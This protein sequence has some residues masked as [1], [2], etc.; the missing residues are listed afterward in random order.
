MKKRFLDK[1]L[2][3]AIVLMLSMLFAGGTFTLKADERDF[4]KKKLYISTIKANGVNAKL[5]NRVKEGIRLAIFEGFGAQYQV[6]DDDAIKVMYKQAEAIMSSGC[7]DTSCIT[8]IADGINA[9]EIV[10]GEVSQDGAKIAI[11]VTALERKGMTL[12]TKS[13]VKQAFLESQVD[14]ISSET[15]KKLMN[16]GHVIDMA[17]APEMRA[18]VNLGGIEVKAIE[19][20]DIS[21]IRFKSEDETVS[22]IIDYSKVLVA[23]GDRYFGKQDYASARAKYGEVVEKVRT[24]LSG[25]KQAQVQE[26]VDGIQ[27]RIASAVVM[28]Y[29]P[30]IEKIDTRLKGITNPEMDDLEDG[31]SKYIAI[32]EEIKAIPYGESGGQIT[33]AIGDRKDSIVS[34]IV[35]AYERNGDVY[36]R[37]YNFIEAM[38]FYKAGKEKSGIILNAAK[39]N[40]AAGRIDKK[41]DATMKTGE[42]YLV[43][44]VKSLVDQAEYYNFQDRTSSAKSAMKEARKIITGPLRIFV[45]PVAIETFNNYAAVIKIDPITGTSE[46]EIT[47]AESKSKDD[48]ELSARISLIPVTKWYLK[49]YGKIDYE[50]DASSLTTYDANLLFNSIGLHLGGSVTVDDTMTGKTINTMGYIA[51]KNFCVKGAQGTFRGKAKWS[52]DLAPGMQSEFRYDNKYTEAD[53]LYYIN[54]ILGLGFSYYSFSMPLQIHTWRDDMQSRNGLVPE[55]LK[56]VYDENFRIQSYSAYLEI[57]TFSDRLRH[58]GSMPAGFGP[59]CTLHFWEGMGVGKLSD[60]AARNAEALNPTKE[61]VNKSTL[62]LFL[63]GDLSFGVYWAPTF[64]GGKLVLGAGYNLEVVGLPMNNLSI[65]Q[66]NDSQ[67]GYDA[68]FYSVRHGIIIRAYGVW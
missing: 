55:S 61:M 16:P 13:I 53:F 6:I 22:K 64:A 2:H 59:F 39:K 15:A 48:V 5:A 27:K 62:M 36:Y 7:D 29:K 65:N 51:Y 52:G 68:S 20:L 37:D 34:A 33:A 12:G 21:I 17:K 9:D 14:W 42:G 50:M 43:N 19:G 8:Q 63:K 54:G 58:Y 49:S 30:Q 23:E 47:E 66:I 4:K 10:Y 67:M 41:I 57:D 46:Q 40:E 38:N 3:T 45:T 60:D 24:K 1:N 31:L 26:Y 28:E 35:S 32:E 44:R 11:S 18:D 56:P 25:A